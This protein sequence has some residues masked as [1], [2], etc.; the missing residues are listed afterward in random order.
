MSIV[1]ICSAFVRES[2][3]QSYGKF[4]ASKVYSF[5]HFFFY[6]LSAQRS[7]TNT[8]QILTMDVEEIHMS[9]DRY[10]VNSSQ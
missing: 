1:R 10:L 2:L 6:T 3:V 4:Y 5:V 9:K 7:K 8:L